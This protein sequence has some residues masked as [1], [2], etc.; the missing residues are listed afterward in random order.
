VDVVL[1]VWKTVAM[2]VS[3]CERGCICTGVEK[4][5]QTCY[6]IWQKMYV[7]MLKR[8]YEWRVGRV[9]VL[10]MYLCILYLSFPAYAEIKRRRKS[11][12]NLRKSKNR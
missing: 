11:I 9:C 10:K 5:V 12:V 2:C 1:C 4:G 3:V 7:L 8:M 6:C